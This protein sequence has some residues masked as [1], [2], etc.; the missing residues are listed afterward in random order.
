MIR[1]EF[2]NRLLSNNIQQQLLESKTF[3]LQ[4]AFDEARL[5]G[6]AQ[7]SLNVYTQPLTTE[8]SA[9]ISSNKQSSPPDNVMGAVA[10]KAP[11]TIALNL[12]L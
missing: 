12:I 1:D 10:A 8:I 3:D 4:S 11:T 5:S 6:V 2:I 9:A 7:E